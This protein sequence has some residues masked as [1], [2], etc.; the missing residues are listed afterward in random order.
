MTTCKLETCATMLKETN[1]DTLLCYYNALVNKLNTSSTRADRECMA[2]LAAQINA[3]LQENINNLSTPPQGKIAST[4][5]T[6]EFNKLVNTTQEQ[7]AEI[8]KDMHQSNTMIWV[9]ICIILVGIYI[10]I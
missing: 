10:L 7:D 1:V 4:D 3:S 5:I 6:N 2:S 9:I 8:I